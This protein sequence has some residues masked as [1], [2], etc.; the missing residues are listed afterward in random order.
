MGME[1]DGLVTGGQSVVISPVLGKEMELPGIAIKAFRRALDELIEDHQH[2]CISTYLDE[3]FGFVLAQELV[4]GV[5]RFLKVLD[6][7]QNL[8]LLAVGTGATLIELNRSIAGIECFLV[9]FKI[10]E[11]LRPLCVKLRTLR[12]NVQRLL[13]GG[14]RLLMIPPHEIQPSD[15]LIAIQIQR[16]KLDAARKGPERFFISIE[17]DELTPYF[18]VILSR[19]TGLGKHL[20]VESMFSGGGG[21]FLRLAMKE[22][23]EDIDFAILRL[24]SRWV[25]LERLVKG[26]QRLVVPPQVNERPAF[27]CSS[28]DRGGIKAQDLFIRGFSLCWTV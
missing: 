7:M 9:P 16:V 14:Q 8:S 19:L 23:R 28:F 18:V 12:K 13:I 26:S 15:V 20:F 4:E 2:V 3:Q 21:T 22:M 5:E 10:G 27:P 11:S 24:A 25:K 17:S 6:L 1:Y